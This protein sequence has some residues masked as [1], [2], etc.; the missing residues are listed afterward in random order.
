MTVDPNSTDE[1]DIDQLG[2]LTQTRA[3]ELEI[4]FDEHKLYQLWGGQANNS[5]MTAN[6]QTFT[7][8]ETF[9]EGTQTFSDYFAS[10]YSFIG[11]QSQQAQR[12]S[13]NTELL[14]QQLTDY[15]EKVSGVSLDEEMANLIQFQRAFEAS[16]RYIRIVDEMLATLMNM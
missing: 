8:G 6:P 10:M 11:T 12:N 9:T 13:E 15:R 7:S 4:N 16:A 2:A 1:L 5:V 3:E 14:V